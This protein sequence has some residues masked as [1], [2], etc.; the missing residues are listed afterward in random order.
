MCH[1]LVHCFQWAAEG[2]CDGGLIEGI[3]D[4]VRLRAGLAAGHWKQEAD[5][6]WNK[7][8]QHTGYFLEYLEQ[9]FGPGTVRSINACLREGK[10]DEKKMFAQCCEG[11]KV[12]DLWEAYRKH[13]KKEKSD[14]DESEVV[15]SGASNDDEQKVLQQ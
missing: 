9:R 10:Y 11:E 8:Y 2:T 13:L 1:E 15:K 6:E 4:W 14:K 3:A 7:G 12:E 5:G